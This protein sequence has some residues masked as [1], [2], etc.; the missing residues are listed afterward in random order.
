MPH[1]DVLEHR[2]THSKK[3]FFLYTLSC[4]VDSHLLLQEIQIAALTQSRVLPEALEV[5]Y[6]NIGMVK[7]L[8]CSRWIRIPAIQWLPSLLC[9]VTPASLP[10]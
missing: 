8:M 6:F 3:I 5:S 2:H 1:V 4:K 9:E 7:E 10:A